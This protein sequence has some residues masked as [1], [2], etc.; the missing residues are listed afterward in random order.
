[1]GDPQDEL[2]IAVCGGLA[3]ELRGA[4][5]D[6]ELPGRQGRELFAYLVVH[7]DRPVTRDELLG[8]LWPERAPRSPEAGLST[9]L[10]RMR[11]ALGHELLSGRTQLT[12]RLP[13]G[14]WIDL[15]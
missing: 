12:L 15:E 7:R 13:A 1:M 10:A 14:A 5:I 9:V 6:E 3:V 11:R 2:R 8:V 4:R